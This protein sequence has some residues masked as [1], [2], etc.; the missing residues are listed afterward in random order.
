M[1][2]IKKTSSSTV[3]TKKADEPCAAITTVEYG[4]V[5]A[6]F[7][8]FNRVLFEGK[9]TDVFITYQRKAHSMG[10][11]SPDRFAGRVGK[12]AKH[13]LALNPDVFISQTD[14]QICQTLVHEMTHLKQQDFGKPSARGYH[15]REWA[16]MMKAVG[17]QP[18]STGAVGGKETGSHM[19]DYIIPGGP[20]EQAFKTLAST[21]WRLNLESAHRAGGTKAPKNKTKYTCPSCGLNMWG[22]RPN[23]D[24]SC[25]PCGCVM[26]AERPA[27]AVASYEQAAE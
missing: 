2:K 22:N 26:P 4:G 23:L 9:L 27:P 12:F 17:L 3:R 6:A 1:A 5:Q 21:G 7:D 14:E 10:Y 19:M 8:H 13:E 20:F 15:N 11:F 25:N 18:S 16:M 24:I